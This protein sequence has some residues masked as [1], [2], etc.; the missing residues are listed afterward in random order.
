[1]HF[2]INSANERF[3]GMGERVL[4]FA[5]LPLAAEPYHS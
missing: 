1:M 3:G 4:A 2:A 5:R